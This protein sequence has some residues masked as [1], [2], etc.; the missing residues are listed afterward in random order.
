MDA[1]RIE[2]ILTPCTKEDTAEC[3]FQYVIVMTSDEWDHTPE[4]FD[5][6]IDLDLDTRHPLETKAMVNLD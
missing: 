4:F 1:Y 5:M 3:G 2:E 6:V